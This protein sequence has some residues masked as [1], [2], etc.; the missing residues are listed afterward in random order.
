[1]K[2]NLLI[3]GF[4]AFWLGVSGLLLLPRPAR[5]GQ[6]GVHLLHPAEITEAIP[7]IKNDYNRDAWTFVTIPI[8]LTDV[9]DPDEWQKWQDCFDQARLAKINPILRLTTEYDRKLGAWSIPT[10]NDILAFFDFFA[11]LD[12]PDNQHRYLIVFNEPNQFAEWGGKNDPASYART[13]QFTANWAHTEPFHYVVLPAGMDLAAANTNT[14][15]EAFSYLEAM[16]AA[17]PAV[18]ETIDAWSSHSYPNPDF[19]SSPKATGKNSVCGFEFELAWLQAKTGRTLNVFIT[20]TGW[21]DSAKTRR[22]LYEYYRYSAQYI[23]DNQRVI[24]VTPFVLKGDPG[25]FSAFTLIDKDGNATIQYFALQEA[26]V[27]MSQASQID[28]SSF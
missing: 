13:L 18:F 5:A 3:N 15:R 27:I 14:T 1:M 22:Y 23:W 21:K 6:L 16:V 25:P 9:H 4:L 8:S 28:V 11:T 12:W 17:E 10:K 7:V 19:S 26:A 24:A 2:K 20:E